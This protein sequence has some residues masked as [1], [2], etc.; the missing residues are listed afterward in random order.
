MVALS[1]HCTVVHER[2]VHDNSSNNNGSNNNNSDSGHFYSA[3]SHR[4][5]ALQDRGKCIHKISTSVLKRNTVFAA[6]HT[7]ARNSPPP[8]PPTHTHTGV[9]KEWGALE[10]GGGDE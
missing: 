5:W 9:Q 10:G 2:F 6:H 4:H 8:P 1:F 7:H 3:V